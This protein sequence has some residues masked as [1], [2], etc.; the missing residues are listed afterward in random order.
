MK[1]KRT[2]VRTT[3][4]NPARPTRGKPSAPKLREGGRQS[5]FHTDWKYFDI[6]DLSTR[7]IVKGGSS[8]RS[9]VKGRDRAER[10]QR[11]L[12]SRPSVVYYEPPPKRTPFRDLSDEQVIAWYLAR[13]GDQRRVILENTATWKW[14]NNHKRD[15]MALIANAERIK[16]GV[17]M[18][19]PSTTEIA[20]YLKLMAGVPCPCGYKGY[21]D[22]NHTLDARKCF[23]HK[24]EVFEED[25]DDELP[26]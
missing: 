22:E 26:F 18:T 11:S 12:P 5:P 19:P 3:R 21:P 6:S 16:A 7:E 20:T 9:T 17:M 4:T 10:S 2:G 1:K 24:P 14:F 23:S 8:S 15:H 25:D 13:D